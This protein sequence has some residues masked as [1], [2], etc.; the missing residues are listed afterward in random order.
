MKVSLWLLAAVVHASLLT[1]VPAMAADPMEVDASHHKLEFQNNCV[2]VIRG[3][4]GP[5]EKSDDLFDAKAVVVVA[6]TGSKA[7][8]LNLP[9]GK[10]VDLPPTKP[11]DTWWAPAGRIGVENTSNSRVEFLVIEPQTGCV[12]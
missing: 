4:F 8:R 1:S 6:L 12:N 5:G 10:S 3:S 7:T 11:G 2:R 9:D